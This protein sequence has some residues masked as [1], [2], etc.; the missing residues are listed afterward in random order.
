M[1]WPA[2]NAL[3]TFAVSFCKDVEVED[4]S[5]VSYDTT[6][7]HKKSDVLLAIQD[8]ESFTAL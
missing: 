1:R 7:E 4:S 2:F 8:F 3:S 5:M 6:A